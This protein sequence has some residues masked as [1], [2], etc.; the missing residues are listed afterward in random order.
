MI[1]NNNITEEGLNEIQDIKTAHGKG[2]AIIKSPNG[3]YW[4]V[5][6]DTHFKGKL[7]PG[8]YL[9]IPNKYSY[10]R[11][12]DIQLNATDKVK[13]MQ[14]LEISDGFGLER[15][16]ITTFYFHQVDNDTFKGN[17]T[18]LFI[19][20]DDGSFYG[21]NTAG[22]YDNVHFNGSVIRG[23]NLPIAPTYRAFGTVEFPEEENDVFGF[24]LTILGYIATVILI[25]IILVL[26][27]RTYNKIRYAKRDNRNIQRQRNARNT[28]TFWNSKNSRDT[29]NLWGTQK[30]R[31]NRR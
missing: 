15:R 2:H 8:D 13:I 26:G 19:S 16:D 27:I 3:T 28:T 20:N 10:F 1:L 14:K 23:S 6:N 17:V 29:K 5:V 11:S 18:D 4:A 7:N 30:N 9:S 25:I 24:I 22:A 12:G 31:K 21:M